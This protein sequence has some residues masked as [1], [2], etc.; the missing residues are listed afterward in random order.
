MTSSDPHASVWYAFL[1]I[2]SKIITFLLSVCGELKAIQQIIRT[3]AF[4]KC[5]YQFDCAKFFSGMWQKKIGAS[6]ILKDSTTSGVGIIQDEKSWVYKVGFIE[7]P[8]SSRE[9][10]TGAHRRHKI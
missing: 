6:S 3:S 10:K 2:C 1:G 7:L 9:D 4:G 5:K 8:Q